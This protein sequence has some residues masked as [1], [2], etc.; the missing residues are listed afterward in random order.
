MGPTTTTTTT[1]PPPPPPPSDGSAVAHLV[2]P[3]I[4][5]DKFVVE[6]VGVPPTTPLPGHVGNSGIAGHRTTYGAPFGDLDKLGAGDHIRVT[7]REG[8]FEFVVD[9]KNGIQVVQPGDLAVLRTDPADTAAHLTLTTCNPKYSASERLVVKATL[10]PFI[11]PL[12]AQIIDP[13][14]LA[15][16]GAFDLSGESSSLTP[17]FL[18]GAIVAAVGFLWWLLF[19]RHAKWTNWVIGAIPF[20]VVLFFFY[21]YV[22]RA[23]PANY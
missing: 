4:G 2:I 21:T 16:S 3:K 10:A 18:W 20:A 17:T 19:H 15:T 9:E 5:V 1:A 22:E 8:S 23:L 7:T 12:P 6:G 13:T 14:I 11:P